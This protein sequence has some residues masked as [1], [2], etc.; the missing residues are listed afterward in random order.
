MSTE[1]TAA[2]T[3]AIPLIENDDFAKVALLVG[4]IVSAERHPNA[5]TEYPAEKHQF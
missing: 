4:A 1:P 2:E 3:P 5:D